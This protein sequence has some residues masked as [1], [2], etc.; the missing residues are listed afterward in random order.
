MTIL[1]NK[2]PPFARGYRCMTSVYFRVINII[3]H[4]YDVFIQRFRIGSIFI[5]TFF[6]QLLDLTISMKRT[7]EKKKQRP[8][9]DAHE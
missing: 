9:C 6:L 3:R 8:F 4:E 7:K 2:K 5:Y 1:I